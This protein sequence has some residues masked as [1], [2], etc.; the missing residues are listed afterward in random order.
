[1]KNIDLC[2]RVGAAALLS[3]VFAA[4][5]A[6]AAPV[7]ASMNLNAFAA[8]DAGASATDPQTASWSGA[9]TALTITSAASVAGVE[10]GGTAAAAWSADGNSGSVTFSDYHWNFQQRG[11]AGLTGGADWT[12]TFVADADGTFSL[13]YDVSGAGNTFGFWGWAIGWNGSGAVPDLRNALNPTANGVFT[14]AIVAG[15]TYTISL[16][17]NANISGAPA[18]QAGRMD[19]L[20]QFSVA[21]DPQNLPEPASL[22]LTGLALVGLG[23]SRRR[24]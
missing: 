6:H 15:Q 19:G 22:L 8:N 17:N 14:D 12:Y 3:L 7:S 1:M 18:G 16:T 2:S 20:F 9:P 13:S 11:G 23:A 5:V 24:R 21:A 10:T 4:S